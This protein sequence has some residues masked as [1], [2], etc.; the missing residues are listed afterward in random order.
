[1]SDFIEI[2]GL[3]VVKGDTLEALIRSI[4]LQLAQYNQ[5]IRVN[6]ATTQEQT[7]KIAALQRRLAAAEDKITT[8]ESDSVKGSAAPV[9]D[10]T[11]APQ[12]EE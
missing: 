3:Q 6:A 5:R 7:A 1:M 9:V 8:L 2:S 10:V 11:S 4:D 12:I